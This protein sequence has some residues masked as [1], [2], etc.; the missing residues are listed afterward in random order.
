[1]KNPAHFHT[2]GGGGG[3][4]KGADHLP[5]SFFSAYII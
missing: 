5:S 1:M 4:N 3:G 2:G